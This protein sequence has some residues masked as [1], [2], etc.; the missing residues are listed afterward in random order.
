[1]I[2]KKK[3]GVHLVAI[4]AKGK[5]FDLS[6]IRQRSSFTLFFPKAVAYRK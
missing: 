2:I 3:N 6:E 5:K 4:H 1:M